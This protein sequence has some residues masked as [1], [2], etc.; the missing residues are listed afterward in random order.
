MEEAAAAGVGAKRRPA[1][2]VIGWRLAASC[3]TLSSPAL[4]PSSPR[5]PTPLAYWPRPGSPSI[6][7]RLDLAFFLSAR[8]PWPPSGL[9]A[10]ILWAPLGD[11]LQSDSDCQV[12]FG[13]MSDRVVMM[14]L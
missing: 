2:A 9:A 11:W 6:P 10:S 8:L 12:D 7:S 5:P 4:I 3:L 14:F 1:P 13:R